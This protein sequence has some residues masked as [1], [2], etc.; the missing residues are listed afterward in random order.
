MPMWKRLLI[1]FAAMVVASLVVGLLWRGLFDTGIPSYFSGVV[2][3]VAALVVWEF[4][5][6]K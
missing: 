3:G 5:R 1:T 6:S 2:G 4:L